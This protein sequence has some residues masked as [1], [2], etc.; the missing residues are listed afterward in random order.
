M[1]LNQV[2]D[3][4]ARSWPQAAWMSRPRLFLTTVT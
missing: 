4:A 3:V 2:R 1:D